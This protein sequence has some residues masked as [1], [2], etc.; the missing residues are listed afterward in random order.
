MGLGDTAKKIQTVADR[1]EQL[2]VQVKDV[3]ER[4]MGVEESTTETVQRVRTLERELAEQRALIEA[5]A[6]DQGVDVAAV[7]TD[8][9]IEEVD[10][11]AESESPNGGTS[12]TATDEMA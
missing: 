8:A 5:I 7:E 1:A 2:Y 3:S 9:V 4:L 6:E 10:P 12:E 11:T